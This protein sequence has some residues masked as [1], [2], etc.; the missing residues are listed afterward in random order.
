MMK[1]KKGIDPGVFLTAMLLAACVVFAPVR[2]YASESVVFTDEDEAAYR[3]LPAKMTTK[4]EE[5]VNRLYDKLEKAENKDEYPG[6]L[7]GLRQKKEEITE[8][9]KTINDIEITIAM[10]VNNES[11]RERMSAQDAMSLQAYIETLSE[12]DRGQIEGYEDVKALVKELAGKERNTVIR[13]LIVIAAVIVVL[14]VALSVR[15]LVRRKKRAGKEDAGG[16]DPFRF[17]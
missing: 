1:R 9:K 10:Q 6:A 12:Y 3:A 17:G 4:Y 13:V 15:I 7:A 8:I 5:E 11:A 16:R 14:Y 2:T